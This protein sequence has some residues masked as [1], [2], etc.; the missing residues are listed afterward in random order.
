M[1]FYSLKIWLSEIKNKLFQVRGS[2]NIITSNLAKKYK[3]TY[4]IR[5]NNNSIDLG[6]AKL[7][8]ILIHVRGN[9]NR[10]V[11]GKSCYL[12]NTNLM[13][14]GNN[15][16]IFIGANTTIESAHIDVKEN[17]MKISIAETVCFPM[18]FLFL[19]QTLTALL[20]MKENASIRL[21][22]LV[23]VRMSG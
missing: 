16:E 13:F 4:N 5:G 20:I 9:N 23:L 6:N 11:I 2:G 21:S 22:Q 8:Q 18:R 1:S 3:V 14:E 10:L 19:P 15:C 12:K 7:H 17:N